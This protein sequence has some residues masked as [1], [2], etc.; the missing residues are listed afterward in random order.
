MTTEGRLGAS[1]AETV[2]LARSERGLSVAA[3]ADRSGVSR[4]MITKI[5]RSEAQ[6]TAVLL[7]RL[8]AALGLTL[9]QLVA[10]AEG[11]AE[12]LRPRDL[13]PT[14]ADPE[15]GYVRRAVTAP[16]EPVEV[17]EVSMP[18]GASVTYD[19]AAYFRHHVLWVLAGRLEVTEGAHQHRL[20]TGDC[21][22][23]GPPARCTYANPTSRTTRYAVLLAAR[24]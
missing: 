1:L 17:V 19:A 5:E 6:P 22:T 24:P 7:G 8:S 15:T 3:L 18:G 2:R 4:A 14:W 23:L 10:R 13:Q 16:G 20:S 21:L 11:D 12:R 9:S